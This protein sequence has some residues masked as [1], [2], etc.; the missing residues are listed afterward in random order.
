MIKKNNRKILIMIIFFVL[1][2]W[3]ATVVAFGAVDINWQTNNSAILSN[4]SIVED[5]LRWISWSITKLICTIAAACETLYDKTFGLID[6][7]NYPSIN[8][9][10][11][12]LKPVL[13]A[14]TVLC[15]I[16]LGI[17]YIVG[18]EKK[19]IVRNILIGILAV[20]CST[21]IFTTANSLANSFKN[22]ILEENEVESQAYLLVNDNVI[23]LVGVDKQSNILNLN[24]KAG[25][26]IIHNAGITSKDS[27]E[28][29]DY[30]EV[31][32]WSDKDEGQNVYG[33]SDTFNELIKN[34][35][36]KVQNQYKAVENYNG[37]LTTTIG[38]KFFYRY[39]FDFWSCALQIIA[40]I[41]IFVSLAYKNVRIAYELVVS[42]IMVFMYAADVASGERL[43]HILFFI[44]DT[45][46]TLC[47]SVLC[48]KLYS[49]FTGAITSLG[50]TGM[51]KGIVSIFIAF[52]VIDGTNLVERILGMDAGLR[53][54][55]GRTM[56]MFG[57][58][59]AGS[60]MGLSAAKRAT[61]TVNNLTNRSKKKS[62]KVEQQNSENAM[63]EKN[64]GKSNPRKQSSNEGSS[65]GAF[66]NDG[67]KSENK[68]KKKTDTEFMDNRKSEV[69]KAENFMNKPDIKQDVNSRDIDSHNGQS[70]DF[71]N[72]NQGT[73]KEMDGL[74]NNF[75][76]S[77][78]KA[79]SNKS[80][81]ELHRNN[82]P[83]VMNQEF[84]DVISRLSP[85]E[86]ASVG[87]RKDFNR[88]VNNIVRGDHKA[89]RPP[90]NSRAAYKQ[91]NYQK[92]LEIERA[93]KS[94]DRKG[95]EKYGK[96]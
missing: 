18:Q 77:K 29:I 1:V 21:Y 85:S 45:Y 71:M 40:L 96:K 92:A 3:A 10:V 7:T 95:D 66:M 38:N 37:F 28:D 70:T 19:P 36:V 49:I 2:F 8:E 32:N 74:M 87:E 33:W 86:N 93:Y 14:F 54:S 50:I 5:A 79:S 91:T 72:N 84:K 16:G 20:S 76:G 41:I 89:I 52:A 69:E 68:Q 83:R 61:G 90:A 4:A 94:Y 31:L 78:E 81:Q 34:R 65:S 80:G 22:G 55:M 30:T 64:T 27:M 56:A 9:L 59:R 60:R 43:K 12:K 39:S 63:H 47:V 48:V 42:R 82:K 44:R 67:S 53:S 75:F 51:A 88:Q 11:N 23:D 62:D 24:Y 25:S 15:T 58:A 17:I 26:G 73:D 13:V 57:M 6:I 46:I 35:A